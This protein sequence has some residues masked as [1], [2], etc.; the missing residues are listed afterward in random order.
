MGHKYD[1]VFS[2]NL[3]FPVLFF[4]G[5]HMIYYDKIVWCNTGKNTY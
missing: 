4:S 3:E 1:N 2:P 5:Q